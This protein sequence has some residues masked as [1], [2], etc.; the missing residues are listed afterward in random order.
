MENE[1]KQMEKEE[2]QLL[3]ILSGMVVFVLSIAIIF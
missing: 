3:A 2:K 1:E